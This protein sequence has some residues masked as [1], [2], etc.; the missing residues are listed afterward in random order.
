[1]RTVF[2]SYAKSRPLKPVFCRPADPESKGKVE[3]AVRYVKHNFLLNVST[4]PLRTGRR[5]L[6]PGY[7]EQEAVWF[8][9][10]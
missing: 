3:N 4:V 2:E 9:P 10:R 1:M 7:P 5:R 8:I 6:K